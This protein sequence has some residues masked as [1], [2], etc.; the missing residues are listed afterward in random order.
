MTSSD[1]E[2]LSRVTEIIYVTNTDKNNYS[3]L[4]S[5]LE[6]CR[7]YRFF[8]DFKNWTPSKYAILEKD[9]L[10]L[11]HCIHHPFDWLGS[12]AVLTEKLL[13]LVLKVKAVMKTNFVKM[14]PLN[15]VL[16]KEHGLKVLKN[17]DALNAP[18]RFVTTFWPPLALL[19][20]YLALPIFINFNLF[21]SYRYGCV[22][23]V[24]W[25]NS[26]VALTNLMQLQGPTLKGA[27]MMIHQ[28]L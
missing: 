28:D 21:I 3:N 18:Q 14:V 19:A 4:K 9:C 25:Q 22:T 8:K 1:F 26:G 20:P 16:M 15:A 11:G 5:L 17:K 27:Q 24:S 12:V 10:D 13:L 2:R 6:N 7:K 23:R